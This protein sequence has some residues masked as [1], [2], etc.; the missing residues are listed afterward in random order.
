MTTIGQYSWAFFKNLEHLSESKRF[1][2]FLHVDFEP[3]RYNILT[4]FKNQLSTTNRCCS[5]FSK[6]NFHMHTVWNVQTLVTLYK[7]NHNIIIGIKLV[8]FRTYLPL[9]L[10]IKSK[11]R[12]IKF[13]NIRTAFELKSSWSRVLSA[14][15]FFST[16]EFETFYETNALK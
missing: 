5:S 4:V 2:F 11:Y 14:N 15:F 3:N 7:P 13:L 6:L 10:S 16:P 8:Y 1:L 9:Y 12:H